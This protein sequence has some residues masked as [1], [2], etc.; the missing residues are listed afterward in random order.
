MRAGKVLRPGVDVDSVS[1]NVDG[2]SSSVGAKALPLLQVPGHHAGP[3]YGG[4]TQEE[5][6]A[7]TLGCA[8]GHP[9][10]TRG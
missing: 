2:S 10:D 5:T 8:R 7:R 1:L 6:E 4:G 9:A 3:A